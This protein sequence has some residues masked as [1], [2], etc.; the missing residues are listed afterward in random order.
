MQEICVTYL[1]ALLSA[2][3][4]WITNNAFQ[5]SCFSLLYKFIIYTFMY[6]SMR[7]CTT[8]LPLQIAP[9]LSINKFYVL[10]NPYKGFHR[11]TWLKNREKCASSTASSTLAS[12]HTMK[13]DLPP[14]SRVTGLRLLFAANWI[15]IFPV[16]VD[17]VKASCKKKYK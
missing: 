4:E 15:S 10:W 3:L 1:R 13:G 9:N 12:S 6:I 16:S 14:R 7:T 2:C 8:A 11:C 17:P 5:S